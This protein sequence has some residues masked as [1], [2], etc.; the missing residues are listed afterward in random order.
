MVIEAELPY[1]YR[2]VAPI[3][4]SWSHR[5]DTDLP[6]FWQVPKAG[7]TIIQNILSQCL[8]TVR[9]SHIG[10]NNIGSVSANVFRLHL[11]LLI[12]YFIAY[13]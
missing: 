8:D 11:V 1:A 5:K 12:D 9:A 4:D 7:G 3:D 2:Y 13:L 10:R 6:L